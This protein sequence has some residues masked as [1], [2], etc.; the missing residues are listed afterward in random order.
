MV[1]QIYSLVSTNKIKFLRET[2]LKKLDTVKV[3]GLKEDSIP[4]SFSFK[5][6]F[7]DKVLRR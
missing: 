5:L 6:H 3:T 4:N 7:R 1:A 2:C